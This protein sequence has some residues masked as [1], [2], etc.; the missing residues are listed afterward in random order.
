MKTHTVRNL[1]LLLALLALTWPLRAQQQPAPILPDPK[2][3]PGDV[4]DVTAEDIC[5]P[6]Y[7]KKVR[8]VPQPVKE[9]VYREYGVTAHPH[10]SYEVDHCAT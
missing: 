4:F 10:G 5:V 6:G 3:T 8:N 9:E 2:L 1:L 7:T